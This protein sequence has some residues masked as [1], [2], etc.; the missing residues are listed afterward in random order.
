LSF[1]GNLSFLK[2]KKTK[3]RNPESSKNL[4]FCPQ[5]TKIMFSALRS[6]LVHFILN[7]G[8]LLRRYG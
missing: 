1:S 8:G 2:K 7:S 4:T 6:L 5:S 3:S